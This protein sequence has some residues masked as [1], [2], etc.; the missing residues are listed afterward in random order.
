MKYTVSETNQPTAPSAAAWGI[1]HHPHT[2][3]SLG[4]DS[5]TNCKET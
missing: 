5:D 2:G 4:H 3:L 1:K